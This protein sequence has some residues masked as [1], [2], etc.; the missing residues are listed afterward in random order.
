MRGYSIDV[1]EI[2][3]HEIRRRILRLIFERVEVSYTDI[4]NTLRISDGLL[5][6]HLRRMGDLLLKTENGTYILSNKG[7]KIYELMVQ[8]EKIEGIEPGEV[9]Q[10]LTIDI[11]L[12]RIAAFL[13]DVFI[14]FIFTGLFLDPIL[15]SYIMEVFSHIRELIVLH[16]WIFHPEHVPTISG[17][18]MRV[19][20]YYSHIF[21]AIYIF[22]TLLEAYKGQTPGKYLMGIRV[23]KV[24]GQRVGIVESGIRNA[25]KVFLL[26]LDILIGILFYRRRG[27]L[28]FFDYYTDVMVERVIRK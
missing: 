28:R 13:I 24:G 26:P 16:P 14:F 1:F 9:F 11:I 21:F 25:G 10:P 6:F 7:R 12:R 22:V 4:L 17:L 5:N 2:L 8:L 20:S 18:M 15:W 3:G 19:I 23:V 27:F